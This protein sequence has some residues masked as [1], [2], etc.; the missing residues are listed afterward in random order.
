MKHFLL[1]LSIGFL[2][3]CTDKSE[4]KTGKLK[5]SI[6]S[7]NHITLVIEDDLWES[8]VGD[9]IREKLAGTIF[10]FVKDEPIFDLDQYSP[11]IFGEK[12]RTGRNIVLFSNTDEYSFLLE[13]SLYATP[14]NFFFV[15]GKNNK[16]LIQNFSKNA[17]S[18]ISLFRNAEL[19]EEQHQLVRKKL[20][21]TEVVKEMFACTI[22][23]PNN[24]LLVDSDDNFLWYQKDLP[25]GNSN[26]LV[27]EVPIGS[28]ENNKGDIESNIIK[29]R[30]SVGKNYI[31][32]LQNNSYLITED[33]FFPSI[34]KTKIQHLPA[35][36]IHGTWEMVNDF[37]S[38]PF[39]SFVIKDEF[40]DR[41]IIF[42]AFVNNP[43]KPK[44]DLLF[45]MEAII[46]TLNFYDNGN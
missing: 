4:I 23:I 21:N 38:G 34:K 31:L 10:G 22:K 29:V 39:I 7:R 27:Y 20:L 9:S 41:Y 11:E 32:G 44:R 5:P 19:N 15:R 18:I 16:E 40:Y 33:S 3:S 45:E 37:M 35:Y 30:D 42:E 24:Y 12:A 26:L 8:E 14:Q 13:K 25:S 46:K 2:I 6:G 43:F 1:I 36:E 17:D 28:I